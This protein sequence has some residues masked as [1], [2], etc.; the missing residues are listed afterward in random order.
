MLG[1][2]EKYTEALKLLME[3]RFDVIVEKEYKDEE[4]KRQVSKKEKIIDNQICLLSF[5]TASNIDN[6]T[7]YI[8][9]TREDV[10]TTLPNILIP[11]GS[12]VIVRKAI[13][14]VY[15]YKT[16]NQGSMHTTHSKYVL[17]KVDIG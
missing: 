5:N 10:L 2:E 3:D 17:K 16:S 7:G 8:E 15:K 9:Y 4:T 12:T 14:K 13:G 1:I 11:M 6:K